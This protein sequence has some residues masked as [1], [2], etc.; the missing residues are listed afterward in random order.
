M[1]SVDISQQERVL[2]RLAEAE[3]RPVRRADLFEEVYAGDS[4][5]ARRELDQLE[6]SGDVARLVVGENVMYKLVED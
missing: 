4:L 1:V 5:W 2:R 3:G 6:I